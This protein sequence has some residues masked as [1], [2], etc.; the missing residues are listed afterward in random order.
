[1]SNVLSRDDE[2]EVTPWRL[3]E[4]GTS[5]DY[6]G[7]LTAGQIEQLQKQAYEEGFERGRKDGLKAGEQEAQQ[8]LQQLASIL[9]V[10]TDPLKELDDKVVQ[11]L[12]D[13][14]TIIAGQVIRRELRAD[15]GQIIA[16]VREC[17]KNLPVTSR[18]VSI[19]LHPDDAMLV[20]GAF[21]IDE[22]VD[23]SWQIIDDPVLTRGGCRI[24]AENS[25]IDATVEQQLNRVIANLLGGEREQ[26]DN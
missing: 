24:E 20:R 4:V 23:Q 12:V 10:F 8:Q 1:M 18:K 25:K 9:D 15:P 19:F 3:P 6:Q 17:I 11:Q 22:S 14:T 16:V 21:S 7:P 5:A 13:L 2:S 26:D